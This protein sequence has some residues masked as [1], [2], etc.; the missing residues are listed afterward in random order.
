[1]RLEWFVCLSLMLLALA[2][3]GG[4]EPTPA[5]TPTLAATLSPSKP[6]QPPVI[7]P[8]T[9]PSTGPITPA[10]WT[11]MVYLAADNRLEADALTDLNQ[12]EAA[13]ESAT[14]AHVVVQVDRGRYAS[15][16]D[17]DWSGA[18]RYLIRADGDLYHLASPPLADLGPVN[19][20]HPDSLADFV[21]WA[22]RAYPA[23]RY[24]LIIWGPG[25]GWWGVALD[26]SAG[27]DRLTLPELAQALDQ[28]LT[29]A[30]LERLDLLGF[31]AG[32][33]GQLEVW[34]TL[35]PYARVGV[36]AGGLMSGQGWDYTG[37]LAALHAQPEMDAAALAGQIVADYAATAG[38]DATLSALDLTRLEPLVTALDRLAVALNQDLT[39]EWAVVEAGR[40]E[41]A[42]PLLAADRLGGVGLGGLA[43][44]LQT[45]GRSPAVRRAA[46]DLMTAL[47]EAVVAEAHGPGASQ[48]AGVA[49]YFPPTA[50]LFH[51]AYVQTGLAAATAWDELL[52]AYYREL[53]QVSPPVQVTVD[54]LCAEE[55]SYQ[56]PT[57]ARFNLQAGLPADLYALV[58]RTGEGEGARP[59]E[60]IDRAA[61]GAGY[62]TWDA[63][64]PRVS[65]GVRQPTVA[66][67]PLP[68]D[69]HLYAVSGFY[70]PADGGPSYL[71]ELIFDRRLGELVAAWG[72]GQDGT[73][74]FELNADAGDLFSLDQYALDETGQLRVTQGEWLSFGRRPFSLR[75][76][77]VPDGDYVFGLW[78]QDRAGRTAW[79]VRPLEVTSEGLDPDW[80]GYLDPQ[81]GFRLLYPADWLDLPPVATDGRRMTGSRTGEVALRLS[82]YPSQQEAA[83]SAAENV[84]AHRATFDDLRATE[85]QPYTV[86]GVR[87]TLIEY[88]YVDEPQAEVRYGALIVLADAGWVYVLDMDATDP[89]F[90]D[91]ALT[92][93]AIIRSWEFGD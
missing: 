18:R 93:R 86:A 58:A 71:G 32:L 3:C 23:Q 80:R 35:A 53:A 69:V 65:D 91:A 4:A 28:A 54:R 9:T 87:G 57:C 82:A 19:M 47:Q 14:G 59:L 27:G 40:V 31:N 66:L 7:T 16:A 88:D 5:P 15:R 73:I 50:Q 36:G 68:G 64:A 43:A 26:E 12:M 83:V 42:R 45:S 30:D 29:S 6:T 89:V 1:M 55:V 81:A 92:F 84:A 37:S 46:G 25:G 22:I 60:T 67:W 61:A 49:V 79:D 52:A 11:L 56:A 76:R 17:Q 90:D 2:A 70:Q 34:H 20:A 62:A 33:M 77:P 85:P 10:A 24:G 51:P 41:L 8:L 74:P 38:P 75:W 72:V 21:T 48:A 78:A 63:Q 39:A 44:R 13:A